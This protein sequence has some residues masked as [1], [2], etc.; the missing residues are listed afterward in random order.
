[1]IVVLEFRL[2]LTPESISSITIELASLENAGI[3]RCYHVKSLRVKDFGFSGLNFTLA[4]SCYFGS[5]FTIT[6]E[7]LDSENL[8]SF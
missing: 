6:N 7:M 3:I 8:G 2:S 4:T 5:I 1:M